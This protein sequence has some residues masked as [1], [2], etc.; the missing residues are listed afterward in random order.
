[1]GTLHPWNTPHE[2]PVALTT[3]IAPAF[4][5]AFNSAQKPDAQQLK[6]LPSIVSSL[7]NELRR[8]QTIGMLIRR[9]WLDLFSMTGFLFFALLLHWV[10]SLRQFVG[11]NP[12]AVVAIQRRLATTVARSWPV[13]LTDGLLL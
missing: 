9:L 4:T 3:K 8:L 11:Q 13:Q 10:S 5:C 2:L 1:M 12:W 6:T 7:C